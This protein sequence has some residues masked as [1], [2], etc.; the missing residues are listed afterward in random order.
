[1]NLAKQTRFVG[2]DSSAKLLAGVRD[3]EI[4]GLVLQDPFRMGALAVQTMLAHLRGE[5]VERRIDTGAKLLTKDNQ[6][7]VDI[8]AA[9][10][11]EGFKRR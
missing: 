4:H 2:F 3:G 1:M 10:A 8:V 7:T 9:V 6:D 11:L 5:T